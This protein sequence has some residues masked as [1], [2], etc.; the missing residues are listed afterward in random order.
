[1]PEI[2]GDEQDT[3]GSSLKDRRVQIDR[4]KANELVI[5]EL[6]KLDHKLNQAGSMTMSRVPGDDEIYVSG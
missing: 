3:N 4:Q 5:T 6:A 2:Q 1:M